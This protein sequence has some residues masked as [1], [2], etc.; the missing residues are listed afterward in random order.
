MSKIESRTYY[1]DLDDKQTRSRIES[2]KPGQSVQVPFS[3]PSLAP[4]RRN[5][6]RTLYP[7]WSFLCLYNGNHI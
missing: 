2:A 3:T 1:L 7:A 4:F 5:A 6:L